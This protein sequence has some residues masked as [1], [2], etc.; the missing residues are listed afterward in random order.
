METP[1]LDQLLGAYFHQDWRLDGTE[2][3]IVATFVAD[4]PDLAAVL[5]QEVDALLSSVADD[6]ELGRLLFDK[7]SYHVPGPEQGGH[8]AWLAEVGRRARVHVRG[9]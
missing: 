4:E 2:S 3:E 7:G 9:E 8:R 1:A 6:A 5:P